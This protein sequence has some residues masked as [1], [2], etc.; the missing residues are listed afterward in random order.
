M[1]NQVNY[2]ESV[3]IFVLRTLMRY[4]DWRR[5]SPERRGGAGGREAEGSYT[6]APPPPGLK[7]PP[8]PELQDPELCVAD[9]KMRLLCL[10]FLSQIQ[11]LPRLGSEYQ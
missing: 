3:T 2:C 11:S 9:S 6:R 10:T 8:P 4:A 1:S 7:L 5:R